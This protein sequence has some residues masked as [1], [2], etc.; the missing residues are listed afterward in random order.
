[1]P[2]VSAAF[3]ALLSSPRGEDPARFAAIAEAMLPAENAALS[4]SPTRE[5]FMRRALDRAETAIAASLAARLS[6]T[7][8]TRLL[9]RDISLGAATMSAAA[10]GRAL[11]SL[12]AL[13]RRQGRP[14]DDFEVSTRFEE[15]TAALC[16]SAL[17]AALLE[18]D[19]RP[20]SAVLDAAV[21]ASHDAAVA[22]VAAASEEVRRSAAALAFRIGFE[23][24]CGE[25]LG[26]MLEQGRSVDFVFAFAVCAGLDPATARRALADPSAEALAVAAAAAGLSRA[27]FARIA[28]TAYTDEIGKVR[29][30][31]VLDRYRSIP[32]AAAR[33]VVDCW[34]KARLRR[35]PARP[36][37]FSGADMAMAAG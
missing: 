5:V 14:A 25:S 15:A 20:D 18:R 27:V 32:Q 17:A 24:I 9:A 3:A 21:A 16:A 37:C 12:Y 1:M 31:D 22:A 28:F 8:S 4:P 36:E 30:V 10:R 19:D 23:E 33:A 35:A 7:P 29:A 11:E 34:A 6:A 2:G 13:D 26:E